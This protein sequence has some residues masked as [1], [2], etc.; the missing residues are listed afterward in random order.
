MTFIELLFVMTIV[1]V[2][3]G[4][5]ARTLDGVSSIREVNR[6]SALAADAA[7][8]VL[9]RMRNEDFWEVFPRYN[10]DQEDDPD[11]VGSAPG[12]RFAVE[13]LDPA[14]DSPDG[15]H[16]EVILPAFLDVPAVGVGGL[17]GIKIGGGG[18]VGLEPDWQIREDIE[19]SELGL[20]RDLN[21]DSIVDD[22]DHSG[23]YLVLPIL[24]RVEWAGRSGKRTF[25]IH[26]ILTEYKWS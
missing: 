8:S 2:V 24:I 19:L 25:E 7:R 21:G 6:Q 23:D 20:P 18:V 17:G 9:E 16:G 15:L 26:T 10:Q 4:I 3:M 1:L 13:G 11:G 14:P 22:L 12:H 5:F